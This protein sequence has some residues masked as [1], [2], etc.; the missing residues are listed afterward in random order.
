MADRVP[1]ER[2]REGDEVQAVEHGPVGTVLDAD[3]VGWTLV[4]YGPSRWD[5]MNYKHSQDRLILLAAAS[6]ETQPAKET[7]ER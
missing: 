3:R 4:G 6:R 5:V 7:D 2:L 1:V